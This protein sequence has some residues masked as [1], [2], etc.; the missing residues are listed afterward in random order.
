MKSISW[1]LRYFAAVI[2]LTGSSSAEVVVSPQ[3][4]CMFSFELTVDCP[5]YISILGRDKIT[6]DTF[7]FAKE[8][9]EETL[10]DPDAEVVFVTDEREYGTDTIVVE[11]HSI[12][13]RLPVFRLHPF[14]TQR[15]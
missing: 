5:Y 11:P 9:C 8:M 12:H 2:A 14:C 13:L 7:K 4:L 15:R 1:T 10:N 3:F 6:A